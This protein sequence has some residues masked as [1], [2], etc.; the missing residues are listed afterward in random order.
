MPE[1]DT[2]WPRKST[3]DTKNCDVI[4]DAVVL[5][6]SEDLF[7]VGPVCV[8]IRTGDED[9]V[10]ICEAELETAQYFIHKPLEGL[11]RVLQTEGHPGVFVEAKGCDDGR[12]RDVCRLDG[13]L[14]K[15]LDKVDP[16]E[17]GGSM[18]L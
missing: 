6:A 5:K 9:V 11:C 12:L 16:R 18:K 13:N 8:S 4:L 3:V 14:V 15:S 10:D 17:D 2:V 7:E 1:V